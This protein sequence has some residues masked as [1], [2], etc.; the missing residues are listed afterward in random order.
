MLSE[1]GLRK[2]RLLTT[3]PRKAIALEGY[4]L[5]IVDQVQVVDHELNNEETT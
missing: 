1:L 5:E 4:D 2:I 3:R